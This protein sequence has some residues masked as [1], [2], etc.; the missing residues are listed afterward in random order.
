MVTSYPRWNHSDSAPTGLSLGVI[1]AAWHPAPCTL[2]PYLYPD[3]FI[4][5][6]DHTR[7]ND[8]G[9]VERTDDYPTTGIKPPPGGKVEGA[10]KNFLKIHLIPSRSQSLTR[11]SEGSR[12]ASPPRRDLCAGPSGRTPSGG[13][14]EQL[15]PRC[16]FLRHKADPSWRPQPK[17]TWTSL[18]I[19]AE[20]SCADTSATTSKFPNILALEGEHN[21]ARTSIEQS[22]PEASKQID[23]CSPADFAD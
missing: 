4:V 2:A 9:K 11:S 18:R 21:V 15:A 22:E 17:S 20:P 23:S 10:D 8:I 19:R 7:G 12:R 3:W 1:N 14:T 16:R 6:R 5:R 13:R